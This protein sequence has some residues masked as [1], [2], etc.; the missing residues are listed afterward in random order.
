MG[1][2]GVGKCKWNANQHSRK[3]RKIGKAWGLGFSNE[4]WGGGDAIA[5]KV[6]YGIDNI[7]E[8]GERCVCAN[9]RKWKAER[10]RERESE[11]E[12]TAWFESIL[13]EDERGAG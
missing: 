9:A 11:R 6:A 1:F 8:E 5:D 7:S 10:E 3:K 12:S 4:G 13:G 2:S